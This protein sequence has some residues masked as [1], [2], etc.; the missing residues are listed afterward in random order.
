M[1]TALAIDHTKP[2]DEPYVMT[3]GQG[4]HL[5]ITTS[6][7]KLS[8]SHLRTLLSCGEG[9]ELQWKV[10]FAQYRA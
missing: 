4:L 8:T 9:A 1:L 5:L 2:R 10:A 6:G 7:S 3:D